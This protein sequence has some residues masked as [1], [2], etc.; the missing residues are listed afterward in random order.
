MAAIQQQKTIIQELAYVVRWMSERR[1]AGVRAYGGHRPI[2]RGDY[3]NDEK[4]YI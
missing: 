1:R 2:F 3:L 4:I